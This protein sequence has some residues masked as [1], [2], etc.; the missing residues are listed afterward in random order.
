MST[1]WNIIHDNFVDCIESSVSGV[2]S[3]TSV[4]VA[5]QESEDAINLKLLPSS[6]YDG[7]YA[8]QLD[9]INDVR[10]DIATG[11][12]DFDYS[13]RVQVAFELNM[14]DRLTYHAAISN[15]EELVRKRL[16]YDSWKGTAISN[17]AFVVGNRFE[18]TQDIERFSIA[19]V[20]FRVTGRTNLDA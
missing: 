1:I 17:I 2:N 13:I 9:S 18:F 5:Y 10:E 14:N 4:T 11:V 15:L 8:L 16:D 19:E 3:L 20:V 6:I 12:V 7:K